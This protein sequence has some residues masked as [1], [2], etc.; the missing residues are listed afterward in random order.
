LPI[1]PVTSLPVG[2]AR[3][4]DDLWSGG[5]AKGENKMAEMTSKQRLLAA[6]AHQEPDRVPVAPRMHLW[7]VEQYGNYD[8]LR[9][10][11]IQEE[12]GMDAI[13][14][15][16]LKTPAYIR[17][18]FS[19]DYTDLPGVQVKIEVEN[20]GDLNRIH[21]RFHT[22]AGDLTD[23]VDQPHRRSK[24]GLSPSP[25][26]K[27]YLVKTPED[28]EKLTFL[29]PDPCAEMDNN[30][31]AI[32]DLIG[33]RGLLQVHPTPGSGIPITWAMGMSEIMMAFYDDRETFDRLVKIFEETH[34]RTIKRML[35]LGAP[36][37]F[38]SW[39][40]F[41]V[42]GGWSPK[43]WREVFKP[44]IQKC[45]DL[46]HS[47]GAFYN[48]FDNGAIRPLLKDLGEMGIDI[49]STLCPPPVGDID[50]AETKRLIG[51]RVCLNGNVDA[52]WVVQKG[53]PE[54]VREATCEA[55]RVGAPGGGF[56]LGNSDAFF[57]DTPRENIQAFFDAARE[58]GKY[59]INL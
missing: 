18:P 32:I 24:Y 39:H 33:E 25:V 22:P 28:V 13:F 7:S 52:I 41:G 56:I 48:Y 19:G 46:V 44:L 12:F 49:L 3:G 54:Q 36:L 57:M 10:F 20:L 5:L 1:Q 15:V 53:T 16:Y 4:F 59:P 6:I 17:S 45:V 26:N 11:Q 35:E 21:R 51:D 14:D 47:Y 23:I 38:N 27:E 8:W 31:R 58:F 9:L 2:L 43:I 37:I 29:I 42:S 34:L 55:I 50:L 40:D 30:F